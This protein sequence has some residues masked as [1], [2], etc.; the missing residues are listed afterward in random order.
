MA[1]AQVGVLKGLAYVVAQ[2]LGGLV[3]G[4]V[5]YSVV[6][7]EVR[8]RADLGTTAIAPNVSTGQVG[9]ALSGSFCSSGLRD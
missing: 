2:S 1:V 5:L 4:G 7:M 9:A 3:G 6:P 8:G